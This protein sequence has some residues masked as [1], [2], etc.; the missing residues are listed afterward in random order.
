MTTPLSWRRTAAILKFQISKSTFVFRVRWPSPASIAWLPTPSFTPWTANRA[1]WAQMIS[2]KFLLWTPRN[3][4]TRSAGCSRWSTEALRKFAPRPAPRPFSRRLES[5]SKA[6]SETV[7]QQARHRTLWTWWAILA[8]SCGSRADPGGRPRAARIR[9]L[10]RG[11]MP[12]DGGTSGPWF[13]IISFWPSASRSWS[14]MVWIIPI[15]A[16]CPAFWGRKVCYLIFKF[17]IKNQNHCIQSNQLTH[18]L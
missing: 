7:Q 10:N 15:G 13:I 1:P 14:G 18:S 5:A 4:W 2:L 8:R 11:C 6:N 12:S 16:L 3:W 9:G 17:K